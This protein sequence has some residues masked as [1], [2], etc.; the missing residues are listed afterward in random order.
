MPSFTAIC[1]FVLPLALLMAFP[2][3][4]RADLVYPERS[5]VQLAVGTMVGIDNEDASEDLDHTNYYYMLAV[6]YR[7]TFGTELFGQAGFGSGGREGSLISLGAGVRQRFAFEHLEPYVEFGA[8]YVGDGGEAPMSPFAGVGLDVRLS[9]NWGGGL[10]GESFKSEE[11]ASRGMLD[12]GV[13]GLF[14]YHFT[15]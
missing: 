10:S 9:K 6:A 3:Q 5:G 13:R 15:L 8:A 14:T 12:W 2:L 7:T 1:R 4:A 11:T